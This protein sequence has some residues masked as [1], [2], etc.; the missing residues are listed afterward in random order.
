MPCYH[1]AA[2][3]VGRGRRGIE[4]PCPS[5]TEEEMKR[6]DLDNTQTHTVPY[7]WREPTTGERRVVRR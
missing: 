4:P 3:G 2:V 7:Y 6:S 1:V 5:E